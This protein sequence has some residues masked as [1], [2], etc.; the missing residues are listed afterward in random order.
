[1]DTLLV[2]PSGEVQQ[3][4][5]ALQ[6]LLLTKLQALQQAKVRTGAT[7]GGEQGL[8][9]ECPACLS[10][11]ILAQGVPLCALFCTLLCTLP[12]QVAHSG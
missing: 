3:L 11:L 4:R 1:V 8:A 9:R 6:Q 5:G 12:H 2:D 10:M 7:L